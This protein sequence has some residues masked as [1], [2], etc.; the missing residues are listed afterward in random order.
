VEVEVQIPPQQGTETERLLG[1]QEG[2]P[3]LVMAIIKSMFIEDERAGS[4]SVTTISI[5]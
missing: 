2:D 5:A 4:V 3:L 1:V